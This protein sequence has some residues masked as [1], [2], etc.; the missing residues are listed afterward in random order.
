MVNVICSTGG[1]G[2]GVGYGDRR[3]PGGGIG[4]SRQGASGFTDARTNRGNY[5][6]FNEESGG[7]SGREWGSRGGG[8]GPPRSQGGPPRPTRDGERKSYQDSYPKEPPPGKIG[9]FFLSRPFCFPFF[10]P[11]DL[12][13]KLEK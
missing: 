8:G 4:A 5:G 12:F 7:G 13:N 6:N 3:P 1:G 10:F 11:N 2:G 9:F